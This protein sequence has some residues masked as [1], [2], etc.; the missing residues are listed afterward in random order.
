MA[1]GLPPWTAYRSLMLGHLIG[2]YNFPGVRPVGIGETWHW[3]LAKCVLAMTREEAKEA[4]GTYQL[5]RGLEHSIKGNIYA[6]QLLWNH[7]AQK[8]D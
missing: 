2:L 6:V 1:N 8:D 3:M 5:C 7:H 4:C